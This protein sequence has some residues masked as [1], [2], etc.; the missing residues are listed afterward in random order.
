[1]KLGEAS[2]GA[3][4]SLIIK[5]ALLHTIKWQHLQKLVL[6]KNFNYASSNKK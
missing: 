1:M 6:A 2:G 5:A 4:A 3:V